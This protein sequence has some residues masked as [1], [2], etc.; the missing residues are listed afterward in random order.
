M[1][2]ISFALVLLFTSTA[3]ANQVAQSEIYVIDGSTVRVHGQV[4]HIIGIDTPKLGQRAH[5]GL[6]R[7]LATRATSRLRQ[8][9]RSGHRIEID[10][11]ACSCRPG[12]D[13][14]TVCNEVQ[15]CGEVKVDGEDAG[16]ILITE[17]L[18]HL[19]ACGLHE[20]PRPKPWCPFE[21]E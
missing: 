21:T 8:I 19:Y 11:V 1:H 14:S 4:I 6:E 10:K 15:N 16:D 9:V 12:T 7:M 20:C 17:N 13:G 5:C 18:A 2:T 3:L